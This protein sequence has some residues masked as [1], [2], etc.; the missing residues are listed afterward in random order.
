MR[1]EA[2]RDRDADEELS[3]NQEGQNR[4]GHQNQGVPP[5]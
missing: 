2:E 4:Y 5:V 1:T 3:G